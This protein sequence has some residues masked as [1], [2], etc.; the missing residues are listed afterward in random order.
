MCAHTP[1]DAASVLVIHTQ[2]HIN[3]ILHIPNYILSPASQPV[4][5][6][7]LFLLLLELILYLSGQ[8]GHGLYYVV[9]DDGVAL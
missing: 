2:E 6:E 1:K 4:H 9:G 8:L 7:L 3:Y 5:L